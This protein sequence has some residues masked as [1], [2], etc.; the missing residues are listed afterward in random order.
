MGEAR[1]APDNFN[2]CFTFSKEADY[3]SNFSFFFVT[4]QNSHRT[5]PS[6][7]TRLGPF[8]K[9]AGLDDTIASKLYHPK[10]NCTNTPKIKKFMISSLHIRVFQIF[11][12]AQ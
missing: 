4:R 3:Y 12:M 10:C 7:Y 2:R 8:A 6:N 9:F 5:D 1:L 11:C